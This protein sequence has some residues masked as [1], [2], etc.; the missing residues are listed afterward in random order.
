M[1]FLRTNYRLTGKEIDIDAIGG[2]MGESVGSFAGG[3]GTN[4]PFGGFI[5]G[6][7]NSTA[8]S[9]IHPISAYGAMSEYFGDGQ[10]DSGYKIFPVMIRNAS[11]P[12]GGTASVYYDFIGSMS[13]S[14][15][16]VIGVKM[17]YFSQMLDSTIDLTATQSI[18]GI[19]ANISVFASNE[20]IHFHWAGFIVSGP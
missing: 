19:I 18:A 8:Y 16:W 17:S 3:P 14:L 6:S 2:A 9:V 12:V 15:F 7:F 13:G 1:S 20:S 10:F 4:R 5:M 11:I